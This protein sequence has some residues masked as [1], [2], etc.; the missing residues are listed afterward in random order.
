[1]SF[2]D[3]PHPVAVDLQGRMTLQD[4]IPGISALFPGSSSLLFPTVITSVSGSGLHHVGNLIRAEGVDMDPGRLLHG[5]VHHIDERVQGVSRMD[6]REQADL[7]HL[8]PVCEPCLCLDS[9]TVMAVCSFIG[10]VLP[11]PQKPQRF[12]Q[13]LVTCRFWFRTRR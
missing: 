11:K 7:G 1:M 4:W 10:C 9:L 3:D 13:I 5:S 12:L 8:P 6:A 2:P